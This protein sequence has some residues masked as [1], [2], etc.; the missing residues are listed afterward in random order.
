MSYPLTHLTT[1]THPLLRNPP[2]IQEKKVIETQK[3]KIEDIFDSTRPSKKQKVEQTPLNN[4]YLKITKIVMKKENSGTAHYEN[5][6]VYTGPFLNGVPYGMGT[7]KF[8][9]GAYVVSPFING[10]AYGK[11]KVFN[12]LSRLVFEGNIANGLYHGYGKTFHGNGKIEYEGEFK[13][14]EFHGQ[15]KYY[16]PK[17]TIYEGEFENGEFIQ[18]T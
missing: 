18:A 5:G 1:T 9:D 11:G 4:L 15:G 12:S 17:G 14:S 3:R 6:G 13:N 16:S 7:F 2:K 8:P 10:L